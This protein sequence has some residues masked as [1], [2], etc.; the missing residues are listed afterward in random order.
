MKKI[1]KKMIRTLYDAW[2]DR[3]FPGT[4]SDLTEVNAAIDDITKHFQATG[5]DA[6]FVESTVI[7]AMTAQEEKAFTDGFYLCL[8]L[9]NGHMFKKK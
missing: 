5:K 3:R 7:N 4:K 8:E 9:L 1:R 2:A 6:L